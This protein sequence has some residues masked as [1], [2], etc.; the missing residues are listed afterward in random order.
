MEAI[1]SIGDTRATA[2]VIMETIREPLL[3][4]NR[5]F[6]ILVATNSFHRL[7]QIAPE[8]T[9]DISVLELENGSWN[10]PVLAKLLTRTITDKVS[11]ENTELTHKFPGVGSRT[12]L[13]STRLVHYADAG[14]TTIF[15][16]FEDITERR[17]LERE[18]DRLQAR[19]Q[20]LLRQ[21]EILLRE[22]EHRVVNSL[23]IIASIL[24]LKARAVSSPETRHHLEDAH[25]R[26][27][28]VAAVQQ[29]LHALSDVDKVEVGPYL[30]KLCQSLS[31]SIIAEGETTNLAVTADAGSTTSADAVSIG[32]IVTELVINAL[33]YAFPE[34]RDSSLVHVVYER[35]DMDWRLSVIDNGVGMAKDIGERAKVGLGTSLVKAL[36]GQMDAKVTVTSAAPGT[37]VAITHATFSKASEQ[38]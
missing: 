21:K 22:M 23:Q 6:R 9:A 38:P 16:S 27:M 13:L 19:T 1:E 32:L 20:D 31:D 33:K 30:T 8:A 11:I 17:E 26:V 14:R 12:L 35:N 29:H 36:A 18:K 28:S 4:L 34:S 7:F 10:T 3:I 24:M 2:Q 15:L 37:R 25:R 5:D